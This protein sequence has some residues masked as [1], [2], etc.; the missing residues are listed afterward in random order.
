ATLDAFCVV[1]FLSFVV[2]LVFMVLLRFLIGT[3]VWASLFLVF[4]F[5]VIGGGILYVRSYQCAGSGLVQT[6]LS[7]GVAVAVVVQTTAVNK[8]TGAATV[9]EA[10]TGSGW[11][12]RGAQTRTR[13]GILCQKWDS[14]YPHEGTWNATYYPN[15]GLE[16]NNYCRNPGNASTIWCQTTDEEVLWELCSPVGIIIEGCTNGFQVG[17]ERIRKALEIVAYILWGLAGI[18]F[19]IVVLLN[20]RIRLAIA[21]NKVAAQFVYNN[22]LILAV[23]I[24]QI[25]IAFFW[26]LVW[27]SCASFI[28]SQV[29]TGY[30]PSESFATYAEAYGTDTVP[31][32][33][34]DKWPTGFVWKSSGDLSATNDTCSG[35]MG[36]V[37]GMVPACWKCGDP[38]YVMDARFAYVFFTLLWNNAFLVAI[39]QCVVAGAVAGWF[40]MHKD[41]RGKLPCIRAAVKRTFRYHLGSLAFGAFILAVVQFIR[42]LMKYLEKQGQ[43][44]KNRLMVLILRIVGCCLWCLEKFIK[45]LNKNAYIQV[46]IM[47]TNFCTSAKNA[48]SLITRNMLRFGVVAILGSV[49]HAIGFTFIVV[50]TTGLGYLILQAME[51]DIS[52]TFPVLSYLL[53]GYLMAMLFMNIF[54]MAVDTSLQCFIAAEEMG[55]AFKSQFVLKVTRY[56]LSMLV[57]QQEQN[58]AI[59]D[60]NDKENACKFQQFAVVWMQ[61]ASLRLWL[62]SRGSMCA[63]SSRI[64]HK[65]Q[66]SCNRDLITCQERHK[67]STSNHNSIH[68][69]IHALSTSRR[70]QRKQS[71]QHWQI[72]K[73]RHSNPRKQSKSCSLQLT[74]MPVSSWQARQSP[75]MSAALGKVDRKERKGLFEELMEGQKPQVHRF[76]FDVTLLPS[77]C[78]LPAGVTVTTE[79]NNKN[80]ND[81]NNYNKAGSRDSF[82]A[83]PQPELLG[84]GLAVRDQLPPALRRRLDSRVRKRTPGGGGADA[85][86]NNDNNNNNS[87]FDEGRVR[88]AVGLGVQ[89]RNPNRGGNLPPRSSSVVPS[90]PVAGSPGRSSSSTP[91]RP[92]KGGGRSS[93][94]PSAPAGGR[95]M[96]D[97]NELRAASREVFVEAIRLYA[98]KIGV[99]EVKDLAECTLRPSQSPVRVYVR[100]RPLLPP[101]DGTD[102]ESSEFDVVTIVPGSGPLPT[103]L[104]LHNCLF[105]ADLKTPVIHHLSFDFDYVFHQQMQDHEVYRLSVCELV[106]GVREGRAST[107][108]MF[109]QTGSGKCYFLHFL[110]NVSLQEASTNAP[111][112]RLGG[113]RSSLDGFSLQSSKRLLTGGTQIGGGSYDSYMEE[114]KSRLE[115]DIEYTTRK[116]ELEQRRRFR[117]DKDLT[118][119]ESEFTQKRARYKKWQSAE[120]DAVA[121]KAADVLQLEKRPRSCTGD[122]AFEAA[123]CMS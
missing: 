45:F 17:D 96:F 71:R 9:S 26:L 106:A 21:V 123:V 52:P 112:T 62:R 88:S 116:L 53:C 46:A 89:N 78:E 99:A 30:V 16:G 28:L 93:S 94:A 121:N 54:S 27:M 32:K 70:S 20:K 91:P 87:L 61:V 86:D 25:V 68:N 39:G 104:A 23:P 63:T 120:D 34:T 19:L 73:G 66:I 60:S 65:L 77:S 44:Q 75:S 105:Q 1:A 7:T 109:G 103:T 67:H 107:V 57:G 2:S 55:V 22:P 92:T 90:A 31:G 33:C 83:G 10:M 84:A 95:Q 81:N 98:A 11:D 15:R 100:K 40:F 4:A 119:A 29:P 111:S 38:R 24:V 110:P 56:R 101:Q 5:L 47:G 69:S 35:N 76:D 122:H 72:Q 85:E 108:L 49:V 114:H 80:N 97:K 82:G 58:D 18:W 37:S 113:D 79:D 36:N 64:R 59:K 102:A 8:A 6:G 13:S 50:T 48:F 51:P 12:Y 117:L 41:D 43:A 42:Y 3:V 115:G 74:M 14:Q 118:M